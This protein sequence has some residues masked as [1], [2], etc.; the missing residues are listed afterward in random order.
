MVNLT[1]LSAY[2]E[3]TGDDAL[4]GFCIDHWRRG[5]V[6]MVEDRCRSKGRS[7]TAATRPMGCRAS[8]RDGDIGVRGDKPFV[9]VCEIQE[10]LDVRDVGQSQMTWI[11]EVSILRSSGPI[12]TP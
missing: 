1:I 10:R 4:R 3:N 2:G 7:H 12:M 9:E 11:F 8:Q 6:E 5:R